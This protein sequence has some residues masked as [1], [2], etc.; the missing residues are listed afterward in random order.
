MMKNENIQNGRISANRVLSI[1]A[2]LAGIY[3]GYY[4]IQQ[5]SGSVLYGLTYLLIGFLFFSLT[6]KITIDLERT[7]RVMNIMLG[8]DD[9]D[10][11]EFMKHVDKSKDEAYL[12]L[13]SAF[14]GKYI[15]GYLDGPT[16]T[17]LLK[18]SMMFNEKEYARQARRQ[19]I[20]LDR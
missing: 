12:I 1:I 13:Q 7:Q 2:A 3:L 6:I 17:I 20:P 11:S 10:F 18:T 8:S 5:F 4:S 16:D 15:I 19:F 9:M 14:R